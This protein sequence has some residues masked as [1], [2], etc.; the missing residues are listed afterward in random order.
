MS[1]SDPGPSFAAADVALPTREDLV[2]CARARFAELKKHHRLEDAADVRSFLRFANAGF[3]E[4]EA[5]CSDQ[6]AEAIEAKFK[7][8][9]RQAHIQKADEALADVLEYGDPRKIDVMYWH[10][11][12]AGST[13]GTLAKKRGCDQDTLIRNI[14]LVFGGAGSGDPSRILRRKPCVDRSEPS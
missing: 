10:L 14:G 8:C 5:G 2:R 1:G 3:G 9:V 13:I 6:Q 12:K 4:L 11:E 7:T